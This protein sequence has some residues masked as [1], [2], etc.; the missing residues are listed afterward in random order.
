MPF[1][2]K[3]QAYVIS[4]DFTTPVRNITNFTATFA[5]EDLNKRT[6]YSVTYRDENGTCVKIGDVVRL[7]ISVPDCDISIT[8][9]TLPYLTSIFSAK[10]SKLVFALR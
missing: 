9:D 1:A 10:A 5:R 3:K 7:K 2:K 4:G 6:I 8:A